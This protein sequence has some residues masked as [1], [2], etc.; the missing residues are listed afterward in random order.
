MLGEQQLL[1]GIELGR[2]FLQF[3]SEHTLLEELFPQPNRHGQAKGGKPLRREAQVGLEQPLKLDQ[4][5]LVKHHCIEIADL[6]AAMVCAVGDGMPGKV[7]IVLFAREALFL[8]RG[9]YLA[10][11]DN[12]SRTVVIERRD[13]QNTHLDRPRSRSKTAYR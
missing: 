12:G 5:L 4:R 1:L 10:V 6:A 2:K 11:D 3:L 13:A 8:G 9:S 7:R